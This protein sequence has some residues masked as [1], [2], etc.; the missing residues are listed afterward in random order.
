M[1]LIL[2]FGIKIYR[3]LPRFLTSSSALQFPSPLFL[4]QEQSNERHRRSL[5]PAH[6]KPI[7]LEISTSVPSSTSPNWWPSLSLPEPSSPRAPMAA[8]MA[9]RGRPPS[10][11]FLMPGVPKT[12]PPLPPLSPHALRFG[13][14]GLQLDPGEAPA[15]SHRGCCGAAAWDLVAHSVPVP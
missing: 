6:L 11:S 14:C 9:T 3:K 10:P 12:E 7:P 15:S 2:I 5:S 8:A 13:N 4:E 1:K